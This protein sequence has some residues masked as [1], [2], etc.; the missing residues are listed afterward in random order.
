VDVRARA[1]KSSRIELTL[2]TNTRER[3]QRLQLLRQHS[4]KKRESIDSIFIHSPIAD[5]TLTG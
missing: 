1:A 5:G 2:M 4:A 3:W